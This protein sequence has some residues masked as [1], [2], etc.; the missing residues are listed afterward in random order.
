MKASGK[1][2][3]GFSRGTRRGGGDGERTTAGGEGAGGVMPEER[4]GKREKGS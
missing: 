1:A 2:R 4:R 3:I